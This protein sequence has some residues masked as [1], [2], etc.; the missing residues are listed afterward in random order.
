MNE[1]PQKIFRV[2][3]SKERFA[4]NRGTSAKSNPARN[5]ACYNCGRA[6]HLAASKLCPARGKQCRNCQIYGHFERLCRKQKQHTAPVQ[7]SD[8]VRAV[9]DEKQ[10][11][12]VGNNA[13]EEDEQDKVYY[14][15]Y[16]GNESNV[17]TC[18]IGGVDVDM[19]IDSGAD[20]NLISNVAWSKLKEERVKLI[21]ST[22]GSTRILKAYG[23]NDPLKILGTFVAEIEV[24]EK[25]M[26]AEFL[27]VEGGQRCLLGDTTAKSLGILKVGLNINQVDDA[28]LPFSTIKDVKAFIHMD[29][30]M[31]PVFQPVRRLPLP[32]EAAVN[33]KLD[34]L[35]RHDIIEPKIG[36]TTWVSPLV[37]VGKANGEVRLC[38]DLRRVNEAVLREHHPM[39]VVDDHIARLGKGTIWS[40]LDIKEAFLQIELDDESKDVTTFITGRGLFRFK[41]MP[42]GL[43]TAPELFQ[44]AMDEILAGCEGVAWYLDDVIIEG[45]DM[46][47]HDARLSE[48]MFRLKS[49]NVALN[50]EKCQFRVTELDF[51]GHRISSKGIRPSA[52]KMRAL[53]SFREPQNEQEL[54]SFLGLA[55]YM[56]K[57]I[58]NLATI[59]QPLRKLLAKDVKFEWSKEQ[60]DSFNEI[61]S[62]LSNVQNL[63]FYRLEDRTAVIVDA[64][65]YGLGALLVQFNRHNEHRVVSFA[66]KS[67]TETERR[68]C[69]TEKEALAIVWAVERFQF[70]LLGRSF[71]IMTDCKALAFLFA[72]RSKPCARIERWVLRL[73]TFD[74]RVIHIAGKEN[75]AD[76]FSRLAVQTPRPFD[77]NEEIMVQEVTMS[78]LSSTALTWKEIQDASVSDPEIKSV[79]D[80]LLK[81]PDNLPIEYRVVTNELCQFEDV[82][83]RG[84]RIVVPRSLRNRVLSAAH[85]GHPGITMMKN[86]LRSNVWWPKMDADVEN[87]VKGC[88]GCTLVAAPDPPETMSRSQLPS[89]PW[90]TLAVD[91]LGPLPDGQSLFVV[92]DYYSRFIEVCEME[93]TTANDVIRELAIMCGRFGIPSFIRADNAPQFSAECTELK[94]FCESTGFKIVNTIPYWPQSNGEVERQNRSIL[95]RLRIAQELGLDWRKELRDYIL[96][97]HSTKHPSTGKP[98]GELMFGRRIKSKVPS[99]MIFNEDGAVRKRDAVV[100]QKGKDYGDGKRK[101]KSSKIKEGDTVLAKR[102][103]MSNKLDTNF[104]NEEYIV[105]SKVGSDTIIKSTSSGKEYRRNSA[106]LKKVLESVENKDLEDPQ[107]GSVSE[108]QVRD[109]DPIDPS[110]AGVHMKRI[111]RLPVNL[112]IILLIKM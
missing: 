45:K 53:L 107:D 56:N 73:Q 47:E 99:I 43:V 76:S 59:D 74:Y 97:Y 66:S 5:K 12:N 77:V 67:L 93:S 60:G 83:L 108:P 36:P 9:E 34:E 103:R 81:D 85:D 30:N 24:G 63:G 15:F 78:A 71:D 27:V 39:P 87:Y 65:P 29:P 98:P 31:V 55:N 80:S 48:V 8:Q 16:S 69:Q 23:N 88:R 46:E 61:K 90:H 42:F 49:R 84:D 1:P 104:S 95:K 26:Q 41:R 109:D 111:R 58:P 54:R 40:K 64:S 38:V 68:Y 96:T 100:K 11:P 4:T 2:G 79:L 28:P 10:I 35:L 110:S 102:M 6:D 82:L 86:H 13:K 44:K 51:L 52:T 21:S 32:L 112:M 57:F 105:Q 106:H 14:A 22:K 92:I 7:G 33:K 25:K 17:L 75:V 37:V 70:Y 101:A 3:P 62:A 72:I 18:G 19:L 89:Y 94:E 20:A 50:W 91:F